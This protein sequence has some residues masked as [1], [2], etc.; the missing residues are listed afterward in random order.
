[1]AEQLEATESLAKRI[2][3]AL[4]ATDLSAFGGRQR[5]CQHG[6]PTTALP[7]HASRM[8][9]PA[10]GPHSDATRLP[11]SAARR[12][13]G[14]MARPSRIR[15]DRISLLCESEGDIGSVEWRA[16]TRSLVPR[17]LQC[18]LEAWR[19]SESRSR[20]FPAGARRVPERPRRRSPRHVDGT[21]CSELLLRRGISHRTTALYR[22]R[23]GKVER[24]HQTMALEWG[25]GLS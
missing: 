17:A 14:E 15:C 1:M 18:L 25:Y 16:A 5:A 2:R 23:N 13:S 8:R 24:L 21:A 3:I 10:S 4:E 20:S 6:P 7:A 11:P 12:L 19:D 22:P 9:Q